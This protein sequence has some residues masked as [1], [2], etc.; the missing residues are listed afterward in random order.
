MMIF[1]SDFAFTYSEASLTCTC[2]TLCHFL[3][4]SVKEKEYYSFLSASI[5]VF[6]KIQI[7]NRNKNVL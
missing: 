6:R 5:M 3:F 1:I 2:V 4:K 7:E